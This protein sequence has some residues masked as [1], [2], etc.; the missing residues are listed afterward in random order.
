MTKIYIPHYTKLLERRSEI[1][2]TCNSLAY[3]Y[4]IISCY[5][6][7]DLPRTNRSN[8]QKEWEA[9]VE[10][11]KPILL[12]N[13]GIEN[14]QQT[15]IE[16]LK[17]RKLKKAE[18]SLTYKHLIALLKIASGKEIGIVFEDDV[19]IKDNSKEE[20]VQAIE[21][22][23][24]GVD[25]IDLAGGCSLPIYPN[26]EPINKSKKVY[27]TN[28]SRSRTTAGY[29][30]TPTAAEKLAKNLFPAI[31]PLDWSFQYI[32]LREKLR[33]GWSNPPA[34]IHGSQSLSQSSIQNNE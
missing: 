33:V 24:Q 13:A 10:L 19:G 29:V 21:L 7:E 8:H 17:Y 4:E 3:E 12:T 11:I 22:V 31:L 34:F 6:K 26:D 32:F 28:P 14:L 30:L 15:E 18:I 20:L 16:W 9:R 25:Y 5:D 23:R 27:L 2:K 1:C